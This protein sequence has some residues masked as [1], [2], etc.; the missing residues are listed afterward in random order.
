[1]ILDLSQ[2]PYI[3]STGLGSIVGAY[4]SLQKSGRWLALTGVNRRV[5]RLFEITRVQHLFLTFPR[6]TDA[7]DAFSSA[8]NA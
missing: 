5:S 2:V 3:D 7:I 4:V 1:M 6:L 8:A